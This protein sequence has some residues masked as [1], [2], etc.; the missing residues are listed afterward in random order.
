MAAASTQYAPGL[1]TSQGFNAHAQPTK[2]AK[3][4]VTYDM[5]YFALDAKPAPYYMGR[6]G[7]VLGPLKP[8]PVVIHDVSGEED[9]YTLDTHGFQ[10]VKHESKEKDFLD[11]EKIKAEYYPETEQL[12]KD[13][14]GATRTFV[15][16][17]AI[18]RQPVEAA[19]GS[20]P[21]RGPTYNAH[22]DQSYEDAPNRVRRYFPDEADELVKKRYL[23]INVW[24]PIKTILKDPFAVI[25]ARSVADKDLV[26]VTMVY[27]NNLVD[28]KVACKANPD[29]LWY[30]KY[31]QRPDEPMLFKNFDSV[32][33]GRARR[34]P[35]SA[36]QDP[37]HANDY[38]RESIE[39]RVLAFFDE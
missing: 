12:V 2:L 37:A 15:F 27:P 28:E 22:I 6:P 23:I 32:T 25:D 11:V 10:F 14:T 5:M 26:P 33:D 29:H 21:G 7:T 18:R 36:F 17:H 13:V 30:Y 8:L 31:A 19:D 34:N 9:K 35:H 39:V 38:M 20:V 3:H 1:D 4:D 16:N 24:R